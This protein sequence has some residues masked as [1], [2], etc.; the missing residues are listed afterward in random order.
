MARPDKAAAVAELVDSFQESTG[1]VLTEYRGLTVKQLQE[2][3]RALGENAN[4][5]VVKNTLT[6]IAA[7][8]AG[9]DGF[10]D[11]LTGPT[12]IAFINGDVVEAAK[13]LRDFAKA[14]PA[15]VIKGGVPRRQGPRRHGDRQAGRPR[16]ARGAPG[17]AGGRDARVAQPGRLPAQRPARA[18]RPARRCAAGEGRAGPLDPRGW[19][20]CAGRCRGGAGS[21]EP[22]AEEAAE[23]RGAARPTP[24]PPR[25][26]P[27]PP[28]GTRS[29]TQLADQPQRKEPPP[30]RSS[31]PTSCSTRSRR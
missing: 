16:V 20:R 29:A 14:N 7:K 9:V 3:R 27:R 10:D 18:G 15:L 21:E 2:L 28:P 19:C 26:R 6:Q 31:A 5:A 13:G 30:W 25:P 1:A 17:Q 12:A 23:P 4:Y 24:R 11:L 8:E 22:A